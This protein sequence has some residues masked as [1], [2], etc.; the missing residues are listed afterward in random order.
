[1][2]VKPKPNSPKKRRKKAKPKIPRTH[3]PPEM[4]LEQW[5]IALRRQFGRDQKFKLKR[6]GDG[7]FFGDYLVT[8][9]ET[10]HTYRVGIRGM[11]PGEN[12]CTCPDFSVN[13]LGTCKHIEFALARLERRPGGKAM[14]I[15]GYQPPFSELY[16]RYGLDRQL[17]LRLGTDSPANL[18]A[19]I[20]RFVDRHEEHLVVTP[21]GIDRFEELLEQLR[22]DDHDLRCDDD[23]IEFA[24]QYRDR[25][26]LRER[27]DEMFPKGI[28][29]PAWDRFLKVKLYPYQKEGALFVA[30]AG[31]A[32]LADDMGLGKT[33]QSIT[34]AEILARTAGVERVLIVTPTSLKHQWK[35]EIATFTHRSAAVIEGGPRARSAVYA[36]EAFFKIANY[37]TMH[38]DVEA[39]RKWSP[40]LVI[41]DEA[42]RIKNW[43]TRTA[44]TVKQLQT[45]H[46]IVL[47]GT[48]LENRLEELHSIVEFVDRYRLGPSFRFLAE[49]QQLDPDGRVVGYRNLA[50]ITKTLEPVLLRRNKDQVLKELP[51]RIDK[52]FFL[53]MT[54]E[55]KVMH[56][57]NRQIVARLVQ[58]WR[59]SKFLTEAD[60]RRLTCALQNMRM[61][62]NSTYLLDHETDFG[63]KADEIILRLDELLESRD[64][65]VVIF[66]QWVRSHE[67]LTRRLSRNHR[68]FVLLHGGVPGPKR[69]DLVNRFREEADCRVFLSTDAGGVG[70]NLQNAS[71]VFNMDQP[72]NPAVLEQ[73]I[74][75]VHRLGQTQPVQVM[76]FVAR[77]TIEHG[78][79]DLIK[80]KRSLFAGVLD[81][82][83]DS[84]FMG[85]TRLKKF[86]DGVEA[87]TTAVPQNGNTA[88]VMQSDSV[89]PTPVSVPISVPVPASIPEPPAADPYAQVFATLLDVGKTLVKSL[90]SSTSVNGGTPKPVWQVESDKET[91]K[92]VLKIP[93]P[94]PEMLGQFGQLF[95]AL[96]AQFGVKKG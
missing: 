44:R 36:G 60:Q 94:S 35:R 55:Q 5:Q 17:L 71:A 82:A 3:K 65:K 50:S 16:L 72:W 66:S 59:K 87:A 41:L 42:Q 84:V 32:L 51:G 25:K 19:R 91:G 54:T 40:D 68:E 2:P 6:P 64:T 14:L 29:D 57:D 30:R 33:I 24:A 18:P 67:L 85:G 95:Q 7:E 27:I 93:M 80:F 34:A 15:A 31:R 13:T 10:R 11:A 49:H 56:E 20:A 28:D 77:D 8:N 86:M 48:P 78:M 90:S 73:R 37:E 81:G 70:L 52:H 26:H 43:K 39:I 74:G 21:A 89:E 12:R 38:L 88:T 76:H 22:A 75:R 53:P 62:C 58:R 79:L 46:A 69:Q 23:A 63:T 92:P 1:M 45:Q 96:A 61:S 4:S 9:P 83:Q 47:T